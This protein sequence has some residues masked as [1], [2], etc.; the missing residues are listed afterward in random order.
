MAVQLVIGGRNKYLINGHVAQPRYFLYAV[1]VF[2]ML[3]LQAFGSCT[4]ICSVPEQPR[5]EPVPLYPAER[6]QP[7]L[8]HHA[9][10]YHQGADALPLLI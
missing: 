10:A 6:Q 9:R 4:Y 8:P 5:A 7:T 2:S 1:A 3:S